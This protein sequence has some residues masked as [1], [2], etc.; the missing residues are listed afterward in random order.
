MKQ[1]L[2]SKLVN[3]IFAIVAIGLVFVAGWLLQRIGKDHGRWQSFTMFLP[4]VVLLIGGALIQR[5]GRTP[6]GVYVMG[7]LLLVFGFVVLFT[8]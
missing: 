1:F 7:V 3:W 4:A 6:V 8:G 2:L 5:L